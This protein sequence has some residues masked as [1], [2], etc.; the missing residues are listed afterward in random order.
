[1]AWQGGRVLLNLRIR[2]LKRRV[3]WIEFEAGGMDIKGFFLKRRGQ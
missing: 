3:L 2:D 1:M